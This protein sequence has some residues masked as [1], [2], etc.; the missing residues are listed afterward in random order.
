MRW[1][2][3][4]PVRLLAFTYQHDQ[5]AITSSVQFMNPRATIESLSANGFAPTACLKAERKIRLELVAAGANS[6]IE[7]FR[8]CLGCHLS[9]ASGLSPQRFRTPT[10]AGVN[11]SSIFRRRVCLTVLVDFS[12]FTEGLQ[13]GRKRTTAQQPILEDFIDIR[14]SFCKIYAANRVY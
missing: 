9:D 10:K 4:F 1:I 14:K 2:T 7:W 8:D 5:Q 6:R 11:L 12:H 13:V 3:L